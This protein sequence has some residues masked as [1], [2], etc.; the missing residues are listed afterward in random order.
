MLASPR[1]KFKSH[2]LDL[3]VNH[4]PFS[5]SKEVAGNSEKNLVAFGELPVCSSEATTST[6][7]IFMLRGIT[8]HAKLCGTSLETKHF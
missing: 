2:A 5:F 4:F 6:K 8:E 1:P 3:S 7:L